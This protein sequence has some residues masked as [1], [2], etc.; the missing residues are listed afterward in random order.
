MRAIFVF[1]NARIC[2]EF[3]VLGCR[4]D[5]YEMIK[6]LQKQMKNNRSAV[7]VKWQNSQAIFLFPVVIVFHRSPYNIGQ[8]SA[9][10]PLWQWDK[11]N[12]RF[13]RNSL[14][15]YFTLPQDWPPQWHKT[16]VERCCFLCCYLVL[17]SLIPIIKNK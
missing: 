16:V 12:F 4:E 8:R 10:C 14:W 9:L 1:A 15:L 17:L 11:S 2:Y 13:I 5:C 6:H 7:A 3:W